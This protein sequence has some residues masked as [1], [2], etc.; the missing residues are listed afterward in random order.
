MIKELKQ[1]WIDALRSGEFKQGKEQLRSA[2]NTRFCCLGVLREL[3]KPGDKEHKEERESELINESDD[4]RID[5]LREEFFINCAEFGY[6]NDD[7]SEGM[8]LQLLVYVCKHSMDNYG[9]NISPDKFL[10]RDE[11]IQ[12]YAYFLCRDD[13]VKWELEE[14]MIT[15]K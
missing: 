13:R 4:D 15:M 1:L 12:L 5:R 14:C 9:D 8:Y 6:L 11:I 2:N 7:V 10:K 3:I